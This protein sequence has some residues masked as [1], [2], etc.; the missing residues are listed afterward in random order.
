MRWLRRY[1]LYRSICH[2][3]IFLRLFF[4]GRFCFR[5]LFFSF[6][7]DCRRRLRLLN[8]LFRFIEYHRIVMFLLLRFYW[9]SW[10]IIHLFRH[11]NFIV[12]IISRSN[13]CNRLY[14]RFLSWACLLG[15][16]ESGFEE[17]HELIVLSLQYLCFQVAI[18]IKNLLDNRIAHRINHR[19]TIEIF[20]LA[21]SLH[22]VEDYAKML[23]SNSI[24]FGEFTQEHLVLMSLVRI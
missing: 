9:F 14:W 19:I 4:L 8:V 6:W 3:N 16:N 21:L 7:S 13:H 24:A 23:K 17:V 10:I 18:L 1:I 5:R 2:R 15:R 12:R 20:L 11:N 22:K